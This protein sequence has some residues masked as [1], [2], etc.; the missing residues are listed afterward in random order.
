MRKTHIYVE[1][2]SAKNKASRI[3]CENGFSKLFRNCGYKDCMPA[4]TACGP[5]KDAYDRFKTAHTQAIRKNEGD[6][7]VLLVDSE[8]PITNV[9][10]TWEHLKNRVGD[11]WEC[12]A[13]A[14][15]QQVFLMATCMETWIVADR[16]ALREHYHADQNAKHKRPKQEQII[17]ES[18]LPSMRELEKHERHDVHDKLEKAT[19]HCSNKYEKGK[20]SFEP[21]GKLNHC[22]LMNNLPSFRRMIEI[23]DEVQDENRRCQHIPCSDEKNAHD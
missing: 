5:R 14:R 7:I 17:N 22:T 2:G 23:L 10:E 12:P 21:L 15:N 4:I 16:T 20:R 18:Q 19:T 1:G 3:D 8:D 11:N 9:T 13:G 6:F